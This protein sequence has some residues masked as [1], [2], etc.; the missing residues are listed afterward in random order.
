[1]ISKSNPGRANIIP[2]EDFGGPLVAAIWKK[3]MIMSDGAPMADTEQRLPGDVLVK[4]GNAGPV[5]LEQNVV[6][7][8]LADNIMVT[9]KLQFNICCDD[10]VGMEFVSTESLGVGAS[11]VGSLRSEEEQTHR[12]MVRSTENFDGRYGVDLLN[13]KDVLPFPVSQSAAV[14]QLESLEERMLKLGPKSRG[15]TWM[16]RHIAQERNDL[17]TDPAPDLLPSHIGMLC[18][19]GHCEATFSADIA[20]MYP[21]VWISDSDKGMDGWMAD[22]A[23]S[24]T[25]MV[26]D[27]DPFVAEFVWCCDTRCS[28][29]VC[30]SAVKATGADRVFG[31]AKA[32]K[33]RWRS[34]SASPAGEP[35]YLLENGG[36]WFGDELP[37]IIGYRTLNDRDEL[38]KMF[39]PEMIRLK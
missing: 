18:H 10:G 14:L 24:G 2:D 7:P 19:F 31:L 23:I 3:P 20:E 35:S 21:H 17:L 27:V 28:V 5:M 15:G 8:D 13:R 4:K 11:G 33:C 34:S 39:R 12:K 9:T 38:S 25:C 30:P 29:D 26:C 37:K 1:V 6:V 32:N 36:G 16:E 22:R